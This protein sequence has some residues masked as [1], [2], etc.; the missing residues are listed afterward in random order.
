[1]RKRKRKKTGN[2]K[3]EHIELSAPINPLLP[4][5][6][7]S[8]SFSKKS[9]FSVT[10][11]KLAG[12]PFSKIDDIWERYGVCRLFNF[13][14]SKED[15]FC[16]LWFQANS[17][18]VHRRSEFD[19]LCEYLLSLF[20]TNDKSKEDRLMTLVGSTFMECIAI[21]TGRLD[22]YQSYID[23]IT[24]PEILEEILGHRH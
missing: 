7:G 16:E 2:F 22:E 18:R 10:L 5:L 20:P 6:I 1:M 13:D 9:P 12:M 11:E 3:I 19:N 4:G 17:I 24:P 15:P 23:S 8:Y 14:V 21:A